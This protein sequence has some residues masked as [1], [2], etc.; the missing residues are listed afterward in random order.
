MLHHVSL[1]PADHKL[2]Q[3]ASIFKFSIFQTVK[4]TEL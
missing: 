4:F 1:S 2:R 3:S